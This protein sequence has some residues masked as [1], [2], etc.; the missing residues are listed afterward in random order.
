VK[1]PPS[2]S[3]FQ[4]D[5]YEPL[6]IRFEASDAPLTSDAGLLPLRQFDER[7]GLTKQFAA[8]LDDPRDPELTDHTFLEMVRSRVFGI[9][10]GYEDQ[11]DHDAL[12]TDPVFKLI[13]DR[14]PEDNDLASQPTL[15]RFEN[16]INIASLKRLRHVLVDQFI[17]SFAEPPL[18]LTFDLDA[19]DDPT[20]GSQQLTLFHAFYEQYQYLPLVITSAETEQVVMVSLRHGTAAASLGADDDLE[21]LVTRVRAAWPNVRIRV[22]GDGGFGNPTMYAVSER[23]ELT[24]TYGLSTNAVLQRASEE[25]LAEAVRLWD[26]THEP[27]R[28]FAGFWYRAG[29]WPAYRFVVVKA[30]A[31]AQGTNRRFV[32]TN[33]AGASRYPE[34]TY[35]EYVMRGESENRNKELKCGLGMDRLSDHRFVANYFRLYLHTAAMNLLVRLRREIADPPPVPEGDVPAEALVGAARKAYHNARRVQDP[36]GKGQPATWRLLLIKVAATVIV[37]CRRIVVRLSGSWPYRD[38]FE[39]IGQHVSRRPAGAACWTG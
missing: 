29:S 25:L 1:T 20:H 5:F 32:V 28:L 18:S 35:D 11:N 39:H 10:A 2:A 17:A 6:P 16:Q 38:L 24:Y 23:M 37:S 8:A 30:E 4:L 27:Q 26:E 22:R 19:V 33:R 21:Y 13:A 15:S 12:R 3:L 34:A 7:I 36:L 14:S 31:N 9:L